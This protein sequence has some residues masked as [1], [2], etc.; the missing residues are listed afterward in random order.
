M[1]KQAIILSILALSLTACSVD[2]TKQITLIEGK[3]LTC[4][5]QANT[6]SDNKSLKIKI[7]NSGT[8]DISGEDLFRYTASINGNEV[9]T[10]RESNVNL[11]SGA[12]FTSTY[13]VPRLIYKYEDS[14]EVSCTV[15]AGNEFEEADE[16][17]NTV[18]NL[19]TF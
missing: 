3:D 10:Q 19:Y 7:I 6:D 1:K 8:E 5:I 9:F 16:S 17:N 12:D 13:P 18:K 14:G 11:L 2:E 15:D 4:D